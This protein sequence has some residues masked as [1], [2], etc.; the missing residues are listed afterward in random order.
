MHQDRPAPAGVRCCREE[1]QTGYRTIFGGG[2]PRD[3]VLVL[4]EIVLRLFAVL[5]LQQLVGARG[6]RVFGGLLLLEHVDD[7][8]GMGSGGSVVHGR[9]CHLERAVGSRTTGQVCGR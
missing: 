8:D 9:G 1:H 3:G 2:G 4:Q 5:T 6:A 7:E